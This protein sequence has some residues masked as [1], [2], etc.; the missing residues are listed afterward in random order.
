MHLTM[1]RVEPH[2][3]VRLFPLWQSDHWSLLVYH[4]MSRHLELLYG[5]LMRIG[6]LLT[7]Q[8]PMRLPW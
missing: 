8:V 2:G 3:G 7:V 6:E 4:S 1:E 5:V